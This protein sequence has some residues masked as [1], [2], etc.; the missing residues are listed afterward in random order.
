MVEEAHEAHF[1][2]ALGIG[3]LVAGAADDQRAR[4]TRR[5][6]RA[7]GELV[8]EPRRHGLAAAHLQID[9]E[10]F[11]LHLAGHRDDRG[12]QRRA[13]AGDD[14]GEL[15]AAR[16]DLGEIVVE[17][18]RQRRVDIGELARGID[19]EEAARRV[20][21]IFDRVLQLLEHVLL[22]L[23]VA[24]DVG[25]RPHRISGFALALP[26]RA[27]PHPQPA[28]MAAV[29]AGDAHLFLLPLAFARRLEQAE[30]RFRHIGI[31]D[32][33]ALHRAHIL[34]A[35]CARQRQIG[36][37]EIDHMAAR[38]GDR[39]PVEGVIGDTPHHGIVGLA[40]GEADDAGGEGEQV[41]QPDHREQ[42]QQAEN[43]GLRLRAPDRHQRDRDRDQS[44]GDQQH[45]HD[46]AAPP[47]RLMRRS[48]LRRR[49]VVGIGGHGGEPGPPVGHGHATL[50]VLLPECLNRACQGKGI[51]PP[52]AGLR[53]F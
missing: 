20:I 10:D 39:E 30:H 12:Q 52:F 26:E 19:R 6:V 37:V 44:A 2:G 46:P 18:V 43:I 51:R 34:R 8:I 13:V 53:A 47:R 23:A 14:V 4:R 48:R 22:A 9:V 21:E 17:P 27:H 29:L 25:D 11:G 45:Q 50:H 33:D 15:Q 5:A 32:E 38:I 31:A 35:G 42:G 16:A 28:A 7:E 41:E 24:G 40:V 1:G 49:L 3:A 36:G